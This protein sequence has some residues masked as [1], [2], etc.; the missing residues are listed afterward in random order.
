MKFIIAFI[1]LYFLGAFYL[2]IV[3]HPPTIVEIFV[4]ILISSIVGLNL[5]EE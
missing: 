4:M 5:K 1:I 3:N 2:V